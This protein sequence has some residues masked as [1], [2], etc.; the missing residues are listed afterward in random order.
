VLIVARGGGS[1]EDLWAFNEEVVA[2]AVHESV[3][4]VVS[5]VGHETD[6]TICDFVADVRAPTPTAAATLVV[7]DRHALLRHVAGV[8]ARSRHAQQRAL[9]ARMQRLDGL[10]RRLVHPAAKLAQQR[11]DMDALGQRLARAARQQ[12]AT[13]TAAFAVPARRLVWQCRL[14]LPQRARLTLD[15]DALLRVLP[16]RLERYATRLAA[17]AQNLAH[18]NPQAVLERGYAIVTTSA[19]AIVSDAAQVAVDDEVA[20]QFARG[21]AGAKIVRRA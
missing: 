10:A 7:P 9:E 11:R 2:Q 12:V 5:G 13:T 16:A 20:L 8:A 17:L 4:P 21:G 14:P 3:L 1:I 6:F 19:G 15:R 18:L